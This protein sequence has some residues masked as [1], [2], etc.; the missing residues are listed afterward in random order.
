MFGLMQ[1]YEL[2]IDKIVDHAAAWHP[3]AEVVSRD[4]SGAVTRAGYAQVRT[5]SN[6]LSGAFLRVGLQGGDR[7]A[8]LAWNTLDHLQSWYAAMGVA[9]VCHTLNPRLG[10]DHLAA[11]TEEAGDRLLFVGGG[12]ADQALALAARCPKL[13]TLVFMD[14][15]PAHDPDATRAS[16]QLLTF[17]DLIEELGG[18]V[19]WGGFDERTAAGLCYTSGTS[20]PPK[21]VLFSHRSNWLLTLRA[22]QAEA[23]GL[24]GKDVV[25]LVAPLFH[26]NGWGMPFACPAVGARLVLPGRNLDGA[27]LAQMIAAEGVTLAVGVPTVWRGLLNHLETHGGQTPSLQ[28][29]QIGGAPCPAALAQQLE[30]RLGVEV[31]TGWG[32]TELS[33]FGSIT[34]PGAGSGLSGTA[35][36][37]P[38]GLELRLSDDEGRALPLQRDV[39]G[40]LKVRGPS[41]A[42]GYFG[43]A[44]RILDDDGFFDTGDLASIDTHGYLTIAGRSKDLIKSG[45]EWI[46]PVEIE[47]IVG[48]EPQVAQAAVIGRPDE[49]WGER[50]V[51]V[52]EPAPGRT[53]DAEALLA[54]L[55]GRIPDWWLPDR[56]IVV[57]H[58]PLAATGK[59]DKARLRVEYAST[60]G[61]HALEQPP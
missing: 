25:L 41:V 6:L 5:R 30:R 44:D 39:V 12:L 32:M 47:A 37:V 8:T 16:L 23:V 9:L 15:E 50:P 58:M 1:D 55:R 34:P 35:G 28:R 43:S 13:E 48:S 27:S 40:H 14:G 33:P 20:G 38:L 24:T 36:R 51:L 29:I 21:G 3:D 17:D 52:V 7:V 19:Q 49:K 11:M 46:N 54:A 53:L 61:H 4:R 18:P 45:G 31:Q 56:T 42:G 10:L 60:R 57:E 59:I 2:T 22:L 26:A